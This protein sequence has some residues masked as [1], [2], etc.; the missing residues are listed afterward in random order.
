MGEGVGGDRTGLSLLRSP[1]LRPR[2]LSR[3]CRLAASPPQ[4]QAEIGNQATRVRAGCPRRRVTLPPSGAAALPLLLLLLL[5][6]P[7]VLLLLLLHLALLLL[8]LLVLLL[9]LLLL[10]EGI[11][12]WGAGTAVR[13]QIS[14]PP[15]S[16]HA[17]PPPHLDTAVASPILTAVF[18]LK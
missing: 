16:R 15:G 17:P 4:L 13:A 3:G 9:L 14:G 18:D 10:P 5:L 11:S 12:P 6:V 7:W 2:G 1:S 8:M